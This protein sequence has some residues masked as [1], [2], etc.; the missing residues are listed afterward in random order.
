[1][2]IKTSNT[3]V[4]TNEEL[5]GKQFTIAANA[6]AFEILTGTLYKNVQTSIVRELISNGHDGHVRKGNLDAPISVHCPTPFEPTFEVRD[7]GCSMD[8][9]TM[10]NV[11]TTFF[12]STKNDSNEEVGGFGL[13]C[14]LPFAY[15]D[16]FT[17]TTYL[18]GKEQNY[19]ACKEN[20]VPTLNKVGE[21]TPTNEPDGVKVVV[22]VQEDDCE[23]FESEIKRLAKFSNFTLTCNVELPEKPEEQDNLG[24]NGFHNF[25]NRK[26]GP[27]QDGTIFMVRVGGVP[28]SVD[29]DELL[30]NISYWQDGTD[31]LR[32]NESDCSANEKI[33]KECCQ[34][35]NG[36]GWPDSF[37]RHFRPAKSICINGILDFEIGE[38][39]VTA[40][41][42]SLQ[43]TYKTKKALMT[44]M[45]YTAF[46]VSK[47][48]KDKCEEWS[49]NNGTSQE[50]FDMLTYVGQFCWCGSVV[51]NV[52]LDYKVGNYTNN[53]YVF[54]DRPQ[55]VVWSE[56]FAQ[57]NNIL[58]M[59]EGAH[60][61]TVDHRGK[62][63][64]KPAHTNFNIQNIGQE[65]VDLYITNAPLK[66]CGVQ[67]TDED[68]EKQGGVYGIKNIITVSQRSDIDAQHKILSDFLESLLPGVYNIIKIDKKDLSLTKS[69][70]AYKVV[71]DEN[72]DRPMTA[73]AKEVVEKLKPISDYFGCLYLYKGKT[74]PAVEVEF[75]HNLSV[76]KD[77]LGLPDLSLITDIVDV[78]GTARAMVPKVTDIPV[79]FLDDTEELSAKEMQSLEKPLYK[80][81]KNVL[82]QMMVQ[83]SLPSTIKGILENIR[84]V[85]KNACPNFD[86]FSK[87]E[88]LTTYNIYPGLFGIEEDKVNN[89]A[90]AV[91]ENYLDSL[92]ECEMYKQL[93][94][95][96]FIFSPY[97]VPDHF[98][99]FLKKKGFNND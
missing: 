42:E 68:R 64:H 96:F 90:S 62:Y 22:P 37:L 75:L 53:L 49:E 47:V 48:V 36:Q 4:E 14:K 26:F 80:R 59:L 82:K 18:N 74:I 40:S 95:A 10:M 77:K 61:H 24:I 25:G 83:Q 15:T 38:L 85:D 20:G 98:K 60:F 50:L 92:P 44:K 63:G 57:Q 17:I 94:Q 67:V 65:K 89:A 16:M 9:A 86:N 97:W 6:K 34:E 28:Y 35:L 2:E 55:I 73:A 3:V 41:R 71:V 79:V 46:A 84:K 7:F 12:S 45:F 70:S 30:N 93:A 43:Y 13:G 52:R 88:R 21:A 19:I 56:H 54:S 31:F 5:N 33:V 27:H 32:M 72:G 8:E 51:D 78:H 91:L 11:Y 39:D 99:E 58:G 76:N 81:L 29:R 1:M 66:S 87:F 23:L 69:K